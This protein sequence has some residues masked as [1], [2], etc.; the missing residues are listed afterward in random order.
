MI[1]VG[2]DTVK[3]NGQG[4]KPLVK[5]G[6]TV[7]AGDRLIEFDL[8]LVRK[9][10]P[11]AIT[12]IVITNWADFADVKISDAPRTVGSGDVLADVRKG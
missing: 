6:D 10:A 2:I 12:P 9:S 1:H 5:A 4:F 8:A 7:R 3:M 11:S